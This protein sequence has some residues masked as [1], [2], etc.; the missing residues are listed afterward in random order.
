MKQIK[1]FDL[2]RLRTEEC[3]GFLQQVN[4]TAGQLL[5]AETDKAMVD[6]FSAAVDAYDTALKQSEKNSKTSGMTAADE[7]ADAAWRTARAYAKAIASHPDKTLAAIGQ[8]LYDLFAK[9]GDLA[10][11]GYHEEYAR[12][13]NLLQELTAVSA[14]ERQSAAFDVWLEN[15]NGCYAR[16]I[17]LRNEKVNEDVTYQ[18]GVVKECRTAAEEAYKVFV[19]RVNALCIVMGEDSYRSF[20]DL[21][22]VVIDSL[23][24]TLAARATK[25]ANAAKAKE[26]ETAE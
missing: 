25:A 21:V 1:N 18:T 24:S 2:S 19:Q 6:A 16:F 4:S 11:L 20:I 13:Y 12:Y 14:D 8:K 9:F 5:T 3:F 23:N 17:E 15:M 10:G 7:E 22:N 26:N